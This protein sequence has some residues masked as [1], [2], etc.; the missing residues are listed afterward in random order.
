ME[1]QNRFLLQSAIFVGMGVLSTRLLDAYFILHNTGYNETLRDFSGYVLLLGG[2]GG[3]YVF[4]L[5]QTKLFD[6]LVST[7]QDELEIPKGWLWALWAFM[8]I[9][10]SYIVAPNIKMHFDTSQLANVLDTQFERW[11]FSVCVV[12]VFELG[13]AGA[14]AVL[15]IDKKRHPDPVRETSGKKSRVSELLDVVLDGFTD[16]VR[17]VGKRK[18]AEQKRAIAQIDV[19]TQPQRLETPSEKRPTG[20]D[21]AKSK[22]FDIL[23]REKSG[24]LP[25]QKREDLYGQLGITRTK[26]YEWIKEWTKSQ[27]SEIQTELPAPVPHLNGHSLTR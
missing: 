8:M 23:D 22:L 4:G 19:T 20:E 13:S 2:I 5:G 25:K 14:A 10:V 17:A 9:A 18:T 11:A 27:T 26:M 12:I 16:Y 21:L 1:R 7:K 24:D 3:A 6:L 15:A